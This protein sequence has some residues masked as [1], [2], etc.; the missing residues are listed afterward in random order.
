MRILKHT[1]DLMKIAM[2]FTIASCMKLNKNNKDIWL[3]SERKDEAEDN[4][5]HLYKYIRENHP[6]QKVFYLINKKSPSY[7]KI[8]KYETIIQ[9]NSIKH[10]I[11]YFLCDKHISAFQFFGVLETPFLWKLEEKGLIKKKK[12]FLQHGIIKEK[13]PFLMYKNTK[14]KLFICGAETEYKYVQENYGYPDE[15]VKYLGL[16]RFDNLHHNNKIKNQILLMPT[17]RQWIGMTNEDSNIEEESSN[18]IKTQYYKVYN[19]LINNKVLHQLLE[20]TNTQLV[21]YPHPEMQRFVQLFKCNHANIKIM[22]RKNCNL[23]EL[24]KESKLLIT[25]Y[26]SIAFDCAYMRKPLIYYQFDQEKYYSE[27][28]EKGYFDCERDGFGPVVKKEND[29]IECISNIILEKY[30]RNS[31][32]DRATKFFPLYDTNNCQRNY[33]EIKAI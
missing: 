19:S 1:T 9:Y 7:L 16:C 21:F 13:L 8:E 11:Y 10:Y 22:D 28:F 3:I 4:G 2:A 15:N 5:Y 27:H 24:L 25:D 26:S 14:Y 12:V 20:K 33:Y 17:W 6:E 32:I 30:D 23:Q 31:F 18:F 29:L